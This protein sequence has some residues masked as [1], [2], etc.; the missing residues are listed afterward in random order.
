[1]S[2]E[3]ILASAWTRAH[4]CVKDAEWNALEYVFEKAVRAEQARIR[5]AATV[6]YVR[7]ADGALMYLIRYDV[8]DPEVRP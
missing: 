7:A 2:K 1:M 8:L 5:A 3:E 4:A 6:A